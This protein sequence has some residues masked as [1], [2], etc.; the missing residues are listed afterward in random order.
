MTK[1]LLSTLLIFNFINAEI[2]ET[3]RFADILNYVNEDTLVLLDVD[4]TLIVPKQ[5]LGSDIWFTYR[6]SQLKAEGL[7]NKD[8][9]HKAL[10]EW[11]A[12]RHLTEMELVEESTAR[13]VRQIQ[14]RG[15][16]VMGL[17][18]QDLTL[19]NRTNS[20]LEGLE[21]D[22]RLTAPCDHDCYFAAHHEHFKTQGILMRHGLLFT[23][24]TKKGEALLNILKHVGLNP[25]HVIFIN[26][27]WTHLHDVA[28]EMKAKGIEFTGLRYAYSDERV[29][30]FDP[31]VADTQWSK[32]TFG[33]ILSDKD[34]KEIIGKK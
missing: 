17:T 18:T 24:G 23:S 31:Q 21:I 9:L 22:L 3:S 32:S 13:V 16:T 19:A 26:D 34:A 20:Q 5:T 30:A 2:I 15:I 7:S 33:S 12:I 14:E 27:K 8:A 29:A 11:I 4:D 10:N 1:W 28:E 6:M 25:K